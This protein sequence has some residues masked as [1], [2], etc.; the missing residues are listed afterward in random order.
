MRKFIIKTQQIKQNAL[1]AVMS[2]MQGDNMEVI[3]K[4][5]KEDKTGEQR[6]WLHIL[7]GL[8]SE[9]TGYTKVEVKE[10]VKKQLL[11]TK[12]V[13]IG[14]VTKEVTASSE[15][16][17]RK[18]YSELIEGTYRLAAEAGIQLPSPKYRGLD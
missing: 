8:I 6:A 18:G 4:P 5:H 2:I 1:D 3:I 16:E 17:S 12:I 14:K 9:E 13:T 10:L 11:G 15:S 7:F